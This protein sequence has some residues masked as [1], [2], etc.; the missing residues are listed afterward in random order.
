MTT[1]KI[2]ESADAAPVPAVE[3]APASLRALLGEKLGMTQIYTKEGE[4][5][6]VT[7]V[8]AGPCPIVRVKSSGEKDGY[9][10]VLLGFGDCR[11][12]RVNKPGTGQFKAAGLPVQRFLREVRVSDPKPFKV[13]QVAD[14]AGRFAAGDYV[15]V[16]GVSKGRGFAGVMKRHGFRGLPASHGASDKQRSPGSLTSRRSLGKV[17]KGQR[18]AGHHGHATVTTQKVE[19]V[20]IDEPN[21]LLFLHGPVPGPKGGFVTVL[22][23]VKNLKRRRVVSRKAEPKRDKMGNIIVEKKPSK[24]KKNG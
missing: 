5:R 4:S 3:K 11:P 13:G 12:S 6:A 17:L 15:D 22:E 24:V 16:Q 9:S 2:E 10:A 19:V 18:M 20:S 8:K 21:H 7:V 14:I 23:T 1:E